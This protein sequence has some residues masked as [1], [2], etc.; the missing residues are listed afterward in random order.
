MFRSALQSKWFT[1][2][3]VIV[4]GFFSLLIIKLQPPLETVTK[5]IDNL[6]QKIAEVEK[7]SSESEKL[8]D[9]LKSAA[10]LERQARLKLNYK[11]PGESVVFVYKNPYA[12]NP[13]ETNSTAGPSKI[14]PNWQKWLEYLLNK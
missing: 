11:K 10:Y 3:A 5:E 6:N 14:L 1:F 9:Y 12:Q 4:I 7:S 13:A 2:L 8:K